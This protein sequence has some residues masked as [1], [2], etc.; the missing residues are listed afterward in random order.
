MA[1][2]NSD[3]FFS[4]RTLQKAKQQL[5]SKIEEEFEWVPYL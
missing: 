4:K 5:S 2:G 3:T 1:N